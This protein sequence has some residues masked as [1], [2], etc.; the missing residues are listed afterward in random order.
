M[1]RN[2]INNQSRSAKLRFATRSKDN[3]FYPKDLKKK[4]F[5]YL[6]LERI[7][8][9]KK[10]III[11][12]SIF[13]ILM[14]FTSIVKNNTRNIEKNIEIVVRSFYFRK[15][16]KWMQKLILYIFQVQKN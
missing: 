5:N 8:M 12:L 14:I 2:K 16:I 7:K 11:S 10:S 9:F 3:F 15:R 1:K 13:F 4:F 6:E